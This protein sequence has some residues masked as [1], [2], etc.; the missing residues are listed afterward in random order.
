MLVVSCL[1]TW[2]LVCT[3]GAQTHTLSGVSRAWIFRRSSRR[4]RAA[5]AVR[6]PGP[7]SPGP[8]ALAGA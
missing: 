3:P 5:P 1:P 6:S 8:A 2:C 7:W 4:G